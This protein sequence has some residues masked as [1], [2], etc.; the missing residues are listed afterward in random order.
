[1]NDRATVIED[2]KILAMDHV[3]DDDAYAEEEEI[4]YNPIGNLDV[5]VHQ[6]DMDRSL[7]ITVCVVM[8]RMTWVLRKNWTRMD[9]RRKKIKYTRRS[10][11]R[12]E[13][14][15]CF[16]ILVLPTRPLLMVA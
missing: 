6:Q 7:P 11:A 3:D 10:M 12:K 13:D 14:P 15:L 9:S 16:V 2:P 1:M 5:I 8:A 4:H